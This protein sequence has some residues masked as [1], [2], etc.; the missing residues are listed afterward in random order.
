MLLGQ[1]AQSNKAYTLNASAQNV[2]FNSDADLYLSLGDAATRNATDQGSL[3]KFASYFARA[4]YSFKNKYMLNASI[5]ADGASQFSGSN[6]TWGY[7]PSVG[8]GW[9]I[10]NEDFMNDQTVFSSLKL[11]GS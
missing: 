1:S 5:R 2:P 11:R 3:I 7:F 10:S 9:V 6:E 8:A 4:N